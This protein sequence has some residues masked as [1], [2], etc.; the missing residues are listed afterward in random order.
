VFTLFTGSSFGH[1]LGASNATGSLLG[2]RLAQ[3]RRQR[4][5]LQ[6]NQDA[7]GNAIALQAA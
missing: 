1:G 6:R 5:R 2:A 3:Y 7:A 4:A